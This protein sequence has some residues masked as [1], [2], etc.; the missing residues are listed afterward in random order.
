MLTPGELDAFIKSAD[1]VHHAAAGHLRTRQ[2]EQS[3]IAFIS[4]LQSSVTSVIDGAIAQ[5]VAIACGKGCCYCCHARIV[6]L[7]PEIFCIAQELECQPIDERN[8]VIER[9]KTH[10]NSVNE[11]AAWALRPKCPFLTDKLCSIY[12]VRPSRC[13]KAHSLDVTKCESDATEIPQDLGVV[14]SVEA[15]MNGISAAYSTCGFSATSHELGRGVLLALSDPTAESRWYS[16]E[17]VFAPV[18]AALP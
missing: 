9:L 12:E 13:R 7:A 10:G 5:G 17:E 14:L 11:S 18:E 8:Q 4:N 1:S 3:V 2:N 6:A 16:G 15:L